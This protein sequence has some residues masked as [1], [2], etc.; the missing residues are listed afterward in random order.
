MPILKLQCSFMMDTAFP[1]D[2]MVITP[3]FDVGEFIDFPGGADANNLCNDLATALDAWTI[4]TQEIVVKSYDAQ[5]TPP[6]FP[7]G[8]ATKNVGVVG[9]SASPREVALCLSFY[10]GQNRPRRRG[11]LYI[12]A[13]LLSG[14]SVS[15]R[16][17]AANITN[18]AGIVP[19]LTG[20]GGTNVDWVV[21][22]RADDEAHPV[23][24]WW[25]DDE[26]DTQRSRGGRAIGRQAGSVSE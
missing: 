23:S 10:A 24:N 22:S 13:P 14:A 6:V 17:S 2:R 8:T 7:N 16:P 4:G 1:R 12:P 11:R 25:I 9:S 26:W 19:I 5:G 3:H 15:M 18:V 20:L 21:Y